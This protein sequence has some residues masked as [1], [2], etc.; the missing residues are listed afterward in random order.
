MVVLGS[1]L[2]DVV[3]GVYANGGG[4][5]CVRSMVG[6]AL[7]HTVEMV[8]GEG[9][10]RCVVVKRMLRRQG[11][12]VV[13]LDK[14]ELPEWAAGHVSLPVCRYPDGSVKS[15]GECLSF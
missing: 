15:G 5:V 4:G 10:G 12:T 3:L 14:S 9:C 6:G 7:I 1:G 8:T 2:Q 11:Y 13:E